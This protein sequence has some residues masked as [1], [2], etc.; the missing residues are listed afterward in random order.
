MEIRK[1][2]SAPVHAI[3]TQDSAASALRIMKEKGIRHLPVLDDAGVVC[4]VLSDRDL[5]DLVVPLERIS[6]PSLDDWMPE[7]VKIE[8]VMR[9]DPTLITSSED[10][11]R[12]VQIMNDGGFNCLPVVE[13]S[14]LVGIVTSTDLMRALA[15]LLDL[16]ESKQ[17]Q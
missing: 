2:M 8:S 12:V 3:S 7:Q 16:I 9:K 17:K 14:Q 15:R 5:R 13:K 6:G 4:G 1:I 10:V 11:R